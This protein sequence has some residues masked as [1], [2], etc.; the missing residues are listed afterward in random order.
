MRNFTSSCCSVDDSEAFI[1]IIFMFL[2]FCTPTTALHGSPKDATVSVMPCALSLFNGKEQAF[3]FCCSDHCTCQLFPLLSKMTLGIAGIGHFLVST[4]PCRSPSSKWTF[5]SFALV[6]TFSLRV[7]MAARRAASDAAFSV[8][9]FFS[10]L[11]M[12]WFATFVFWF[13]CQ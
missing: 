12:P 7:A 8:I 10:S 6:T 4:M 5:S 9:P 2:W 11:P 13:S 3:F 1:V